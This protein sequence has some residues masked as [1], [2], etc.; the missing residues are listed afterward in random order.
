MTTCYNYVKTIKLQSARFP[1]FL[2]QTNC[3]TNAVF[4]LLMVIYVGPQYWS[5]VK[6]KI[7]IGPT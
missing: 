3:N 5:F 1:S 6:F 7:Y 4:T 2:Y